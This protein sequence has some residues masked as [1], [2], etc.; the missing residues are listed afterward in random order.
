MAC[1]HDGYRDIVGHY[2]RVAGVLM[3]H[4]RCESCG[5]LLHEANRMRYRPRFAPLPQ[6]RYFP[7]R[8]PSYRKPRLRK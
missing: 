6:A 4:W 3:Y 2:D 8:P 7:V 5:A 1:A